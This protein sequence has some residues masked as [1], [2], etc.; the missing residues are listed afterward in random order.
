MSVMQKIVETIVQFLPDQDS[1]QLSPGKH[2]F[3]GQPLSRADGHLKVKGEATFAAEFK[4][5]NLAYAVIIYSSVPKGKITQVDQSVAEKVSGFI[6][7]MTYE[8]APRM[9]T[10]P[11]QNKDTPWGGFAPSNLPVMQDAEIHWN[12]QPVAVVVAETEDQAEEAA[13]LLKIEYAKDDSATVSFEK[14]I[15]DAVEPPNILGEKTKLEIGDAEKKLADA[16]FSVD[17]VYKTPRYAQSALETH[18]TIAFWEDEKHL[19]M[20]DSTQFVTGIKDIMCLMFDLDAENVR[21]VT[22]FVGGGFGS[23][24]GMWNNTP[25][26]AAAAK[27]VNRPVKLVVPRKGV[28]FTVGGRTPSEQRVALSADADGKFAAMIHTGYT[29]ITD[30]NEF[31]EQFSFPVRHLYASESFLIWQKIV[32]LNTVAN[33]WMRAP[34]ESIGMFALESAIDELAEK[35]K[36]DPVKLRIRNEPERD[37][38]KDTEFSMRNLTK[39]Y[40]LGAEKF[41]WKQLPPGSQKDGKWL[42]GQGMATAYYPY[43]RYPATARVRVATNGTATIQIAANEMGMGTATVQIQHAAERLGL[44]I[45]KVS[46]QYGN[47]DLPP[48]PVAGSSSQTVSVAMAIALTIEKLQK[49]FLAIAGDD[50]DS[51]LS[52]LKYEDVEFRDGGIFSKKDSSKGETYQSILR[53]A[54][55]EFVEAEEA[56]GSSL[57]IMKYS[58]AS[59]GAH[60]C[61]LRVHEDTG[62]T[63]ISRWQSVFDCGRILNRKTASSQFRGGIIM[64]IGMALM[65]ETFLD[66][67]NGRI[68]NPS[69][70]DYHFPAHLD[71][72]HIDVDFL[73]IADEKAP[74]GAHGVGEIGIV[75]T[76][77]AIA[78]AVYNATGKR[79]RELPITLDKLL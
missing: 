70:G 68:A 18:A 2:G 30:H 67:R 65:E 71:I 44:P 5:E 53:R 9:K 55:Q 43:S 16:E 34:G 75:G 17:H 24:G 72:P 37:P 64:G 76:A 69:F 52:N 13:A 32:K 10:P 26:C 33:T 54:N 56:S 28:F 63:R 59:Y 35:L 50:Y 15:P 42:I 25:L 38:T 61:E 73:D 47:S 49:E 31:P 23:K 51:P 66:D 36:I 78:N 7:V 77:A 1:K 27:L 29:P 12:G 79:V 60:F 8:N 21:V 48:S 4:I 41:G 57:E 19:L 45:E 11:L 14:L 46:F 22:P 39:A 74:L 3:V 58:M 6:K 20:F 40:R 62:E